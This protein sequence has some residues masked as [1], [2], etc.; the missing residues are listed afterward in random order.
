LR[1]GAT[2]P[3]KRAIEGQIEFR[4]VGDENRIIE[5][6]D[7]LKEHLFQRRAAFHHQVSNA[8]NGGCLPRNRAAGIYQPV[9]R[10]QH[11]SD[12]KPDEA[13]LDNLV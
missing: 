11:P 7:D 6:P 10:L 3:H 2:P 1:G 12:V 5:E 13:D 4:V 8:V 9:I